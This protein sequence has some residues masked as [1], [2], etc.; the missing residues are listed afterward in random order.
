MGTNI[1]SCYVFAQPF[2]YLLRHKSHFGLF[3]RFRL[4][5][6]ELSVHHVRRFEFIDI[7]ILSLLFSLEFYLLSRNLVQQLEHSE[8]FHAVRF[9][10]CELRVLRFR[11]VIHKKIVN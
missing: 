10:V 3:S 9:A 1:V 8:S 2:C 4:S 7:I 5:Y 11:I 6:K